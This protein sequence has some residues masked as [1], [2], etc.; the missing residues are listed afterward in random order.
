[1]DGNGN[2]QI[3]INKKKLEYRFIIKLNSLKSNYNMLISIA[4]TIGWKR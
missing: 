3:N 1:M 4:K 2:I